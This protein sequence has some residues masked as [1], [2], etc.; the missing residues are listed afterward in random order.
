MSTR[1]PLALVF[2][3]L[4]TGIVAGGCDTTRDLLGQSKR[5]PDEFA[6]Y[7]RA[8]L[9]LPPDY[10]LRPP[11][12]GM[13]RPQAVAPQDDARRALVNPGAPASPQRT[14]TLAAAGD[15]SP[16]LRS[17]L[18]RT[19]ATTA[20]PDIRSQ[21]NRETS[22]LAEEDQSTIERIMFW[23]TPQ[24]YGTVVDPAAEAK[25]IQENQA[26]GNP[27]TQGQTPTIERRRRAILEG[28]FDW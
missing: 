21:V 16:G 3:V 8:P 15:V 11:S 26:L 10:G 5:A 4:A 20:N 17:L 7:S 18:E 22:V 9:S 27:I 14:N 12:P 19:G 25:R 1:F 2:F 28:I 24:E 23:R 13:S 6:V